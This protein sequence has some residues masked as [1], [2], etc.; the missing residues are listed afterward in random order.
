CVAGVGQAGA[1]DDDARE[2]GLRRCEPWSQEQQCETAQPWPTGGRCRC[3][4]SPDHDGSL[5]LA[6]VEQRGRESARRL[7]TGVF[8][9][10]TPYLP[11]RGGRP[12]GRVRRGEF[13]VNYS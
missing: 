13:G 11:L 10:P 5:T 8:V 6:V 1:E 3:A 2:R 9:W 12:A 4:V 7:Q